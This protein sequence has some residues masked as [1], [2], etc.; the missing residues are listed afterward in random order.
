MTTQTKEHISIHLESG[1]EGYFLACNQRVDQFVNAH[2][3]YPGAWQ[4]NRKAFGWDLL[5]MPLNLLWAPIYV[6]AQ[7]LAMMFARIQYVR[8]SKFFRQLPAG[9]QTKV[10]KHLHLQLYQELLGH[11]NPSQQ[12]LQAHVLHALQDELT[13]VY[14]G[15]KASPLTELSSTSIAHTRRE[16]EAIIEDALSQMNITRTASADIAN[17]LLSVG[18]GALAFKKFTPGGIGIGVFISG[19]IALA[20]AKTHFMLGEG[21][22]NLYYHVFPPEPSTLLTITSILLVMI[23]FAVFAAFSGIF[24]D[25]LL[26]LFGFHKRRLHRM[27]RHMEIDVKAKTAS[28][29]RP[30]D[31]FVARIFE[32]FDTIS[33]LAR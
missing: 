11:D 20:Q 8:I 22:G 18:L 30:K 24:S 6:C 9:Y 10:Q 33:H 1:V 7:L 3:R 12:S 16:L 27:L 4:N 25:P 26:A 5:R 28:S 2:Y 14:S 21:L 32:L 17:T 31:A 13:K 15:Q 19:Y 29:F 23:I